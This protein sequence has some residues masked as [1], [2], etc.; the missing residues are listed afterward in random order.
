MVFPLPYVILHSIL[1]FTIYYLAYT[2]LAG[3][4]YS[5]YRRLFHRC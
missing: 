5:S 3:S 4:S 1:S 2:Y